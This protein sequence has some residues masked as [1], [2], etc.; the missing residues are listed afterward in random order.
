[1]QYHTVTV[2]KNFRFKNKSEWK[3]FFEDSELEFEKFLEVHNNQV[4]DG[5]Q[6][7]SETEVVPIECD[8]KL[9]ETSDHPSLSKKKHKSK[10]KRR[11]HQEIHN[12]PVVKRR[13]DLK[14]EVS[15]TKFE[16][17]ELDKLLDEYDEGCSEIENQNRSFEDM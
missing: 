8:V 5:E 12:Q 15:D 1:M 4:K 7:L 14:I 13:N 2:H 16:E 3:Q 9:E 10:K 6:H 17:E 11:Q